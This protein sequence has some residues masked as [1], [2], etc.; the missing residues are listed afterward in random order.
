MALNFLMLLY[1]M[2]YF[3]CL[4]RII[5][6]GNSNSE[7]TNCNDTYRPYNIRVLAHNGLFTVTAVSVDNNTNNFHMHAIKIRNGVITMCIVFTL[8]HFCHVHCAINWIL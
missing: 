2:E 6:P 4:L 7:C 3:K 8:S 1:C 5:Q